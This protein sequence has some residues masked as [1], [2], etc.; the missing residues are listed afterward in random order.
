MERKAVCYVFGAGEQTPL[1]NTRLRTGA[2]TGL[3]WP[4]GPNDCVIAADGG[5]RWLEELG[6]QPNLLI[7]DMDSLPKLPAGVQTLRLPVE[8]DDTDMRAA[9]HH[10]QKLG[11]RVFHIYGGTGGRI[12]HTLANIQCLAELAQQ[13]AQG[14]LHSASSSITAICADNLY[15]PPGG[16]GFVS[17]F[18]HG[19]MAEGVTL[20]GL[21]YPLLQATLRNSYPLGV[22]NAFTGA[23]A[24]ISVE[25]GT[26]VVVYPLDAQPVPCV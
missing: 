23:A 12:E 15:F 17:V 19:D 6:R 13:G 18:A 26:L 14:F 21:Q 2:A 7:G 5:Y 24:S 1:P 25:K 4:P 22:S 16:S 9:L 20:Q 11:Y 10:G 3:H 8:K